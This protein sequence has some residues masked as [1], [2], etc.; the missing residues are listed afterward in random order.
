MMVARAH[1]LARAA[2]A[3]ALAVVVA[4]GCGGEDEDDVACE[5][6]FETCDLS[7]LDCLSNLADGI[8]CMTGHD[9]GVPVVQSWEPDEA[10]EFFTPEAPTA[11]QMRLVQQQL[12]ALALFRLVPEQ[13]SA[14]LA[15][16]AYA[17]SVPAFYDVM[18]GRIIVVD[19]EPGGTVE[20]GDAG[21]A[22]GESTDAG[23][24]AP[25]EQTFKTYVHELVHAA[26]DQRT[27]LAAL[28]GR[29]GSVDAW[30]AARAVVEG[31]AQL[32]AQ[33]A[34][35]DAAG[36]DPAEM[37]WEALLEDFRMSMVAT[38]VSVD[39]PYSLADRYLPY[40]YGYAYVVEAWQQGGN[41]AIEALYAN[42]PISTR[43]ITAGFGAELSASGA[44]ALVASD[45][46]SPMLAQRFAPVAVLRLGAWLVDAS[47][48]RFREAPRVDLSWSVL[49]DLEGDILSLYHDADTDSPVAIWRLRFA[50][51]A[52]AQAMEELT[53]AWPPEIQS[54]VAGSDGILLGTGPGGPTLDAAALE[55][56]ALTPIPRA[57]DAVTSLVL[58][59][60]PPR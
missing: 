52:S 27:G 60:S 38:F 10:V 55:W 51:A 6:A 23:V 20:D 1:G 17:V 39:A 29:A 31:E 57:S 11:E 59:A 21:G 44:P 12:D 48:Q 26:R 46:A 42:P 8:A 32:F 41:A 56:Q 16:E 50:D 49:Q 5:A 43:A 9:P 7:E 4:S 47:I 2:C 15:T 18:Q 54:H 14:E 24:S 19:V 37:D 13:Y 25:D 22:G 30:L 40:P 53:A 36:E 33:L 45:E 35:L 3:L 28:Y 34:W 58:A